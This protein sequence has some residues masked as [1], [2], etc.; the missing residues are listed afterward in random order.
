MIK[1][2]KFLLHIILTVSLL[3]PINVFA[4]SENLS[5]E[6]IT[7]FKNTIESNFSFQENHDFQLI[8]DEEEIL[9]MDIKSKGQK[10][11]D[12]LEFFSDF[13]ID[14]NGQAINDLEDDIPSVKGR[15][16]V[17]KDIYFK[18]AVSSLFIK[19]KNLS[20]NIDKAE[21]EEIKAIG[22]GFFQLV[23]LFKNNY[24]YDLGAV[25]EIFK[26]AMGKQNSP[27]LSTYDLYDQGI[28]LSINFLACLLESG[29][30][31]IK[32][33]GQTITI[34]LKKEL[35]ADEINLK[36]FIGF[37]D[38]YLEFIKKFIFKSRDLDDIEYLSKNIEE[39]IITAE[40]E[41][42]M[43]IIK[44]KKEIKKFLQ[45]INIEM[46]FT[47]N[48]GRIKSSKLDFVLKMPLDA[49]F[50]KKDLQININSSCE[51]GSKL[52]PITVPE[53]LQQGIDFAKFIKAILTVEKIQKEKYQ[54]WEDSYENNSYE[55][56]YEEGYYPYEES[57]NPDE[58]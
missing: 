15:L 35:D 54:R 41:I 9:K 42:K 11:N 19:V 37:A 36:Q 21:N 49:F 38:D 12:D 23:K 10:N 1:I 44:N 43:K 22:E 31:E 25:V 8:L 3:M 58:E 29:F 33:S 27:Q 28:D 46:S 6:I 7:S 17:S 39:E 53:E 50:I 34:S 57:Y 4:A 24:K 2:K 26:E 51:I 52:S 16:T 40:K 48:G 55:E 32:K 20:L 56:E 30:F 45:N 14:F 5:Q 18:K 47:L 13:I